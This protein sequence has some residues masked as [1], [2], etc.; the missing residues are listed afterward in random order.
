MHRVCIKHLFDSRRAGDVDSFLLSQ[1]LVSPKNP[2]KQASNPHGCWI[3]DSGPGH[4][5]RFLSGI[6]DLADDLHPRSHRLF[7]RLMRWA[8]WVQRTW[9]HISSRTVFQ[10]GTLHR[11]D[12]TARPT[13]DGRGR[14]PV[15]QLSICRSAPAPCSAP[16]TLHPAPGRACPGEQLGE[17]THRFSRIAGAF[18]ACPYLRCNLRE[19]PD[20]R[21]WSADASVAPAGLTETAQ[22]VGITRHQ[23]FF[24]TLTGRGIL[25]WL[26]ASRSHCSS[27]RSPTST[28]GNVET[29]ASIASSAA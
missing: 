22:P 16:C 24:S 7:C 12:R 29:D 28:T 18:P 3:F 10:N 1:N 4:H 19:V 25:H 21:L 11:P 15:T 6:N 27:T 23:G 14:V 17:M 8:V 2:Q 20:Q 5:A 13:W 26:F 9:P